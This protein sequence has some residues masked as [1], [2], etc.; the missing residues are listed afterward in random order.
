MRSDVQ[1]LVNVV[2]TGMSCQLG[3]RGPHC[4]E[5]CWKNVLTEVLYGLCPFHAYLRPVLQIY[6]N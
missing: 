1:D 6:E 2:E 4:S 3:P 5:L